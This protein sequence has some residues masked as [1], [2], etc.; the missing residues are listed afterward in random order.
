MIP[1]LP[2]KKS[3]IPYIFV[4]F[5]AV[6][7]LVN[8]FYIYIANKTWR[9]VATTDAYQK[10]L[11]YNDTLKQAEVQKNLGWN[12]GMKFRHKYD[13]KITLFIDLTDNK[14]RT[15]PDAQIYVDFKRPTQ[16]GM[17]FSQEIKFENGVYKADIEL[18]K[19]GQWDVSILAVKGTA[20]FAHTERQII[21]W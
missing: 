16:E 1:E 6:V 4:G 3:K 12:V 18:P 8:F 21:Q 17:D 13:N 2:A 5:F 10:G 9:G 20:R 14:F 19:Q 11:N 15:I 7:F